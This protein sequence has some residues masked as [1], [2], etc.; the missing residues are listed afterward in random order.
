MQS[1]VTHVYSENIGGQCKYVI[2]QFVVGMAHGILQIF[3]KS[4]N[5]FAYSAQI[6]HMFSTLN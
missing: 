4:A 6:L 5:I 3:G 2:T 1:T